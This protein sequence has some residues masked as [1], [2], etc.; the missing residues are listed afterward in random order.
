LKE[1][2][3]EKLLL[4]CMR[5]ESMI[6]EERTALDIILLGSPLCFLFMISLLNL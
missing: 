3:K 6:K 4:R 5:E 2:K 1:Q